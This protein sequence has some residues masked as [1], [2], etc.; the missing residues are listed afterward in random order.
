MPDGAT[1]Q[2]LMEHIQI[3]KTLFKNTHFDKF[4]VSTID[5]PF[6]TVQEA[7]EEIQLLDFDFVQLMDIFPVC[8]P[9][10]VGLA[11]N[12]KC[13]VYSGFSVVDGKGGFLRPLYIGVNDEDVYPVYLFI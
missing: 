3:P 4:I 9:D 8:P 7:L 10:Y 1:T 6:E 11:C 12:Y 2:V 5:V 13:E